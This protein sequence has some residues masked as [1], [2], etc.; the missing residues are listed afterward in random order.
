MRL[1]VYYSQLCGVLSATRYYQ[2]YYQYSAVTDTC[3]TTLMDDGQLSY[4]FHNQ[5][6]FN[7]EV[8]RFAIKVYKDV[9]PFLSLFRLP[10]SSSI[11]YMLLLQKPIHIS[12]R[13][14]PKIEAT[15][16]E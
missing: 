14:T 1:P 13:R 12:L 2:S 16:K 6:H 9:N 5:A 3:Q 7:S 11:Q 10:L 4:H 8:L 15:P